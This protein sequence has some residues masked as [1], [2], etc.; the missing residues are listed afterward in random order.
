MK[1]ACRLGAIA[2]LLT[3]M[4]SAGI[5]QSAVV[6][7]DLVADGDSRFFE[8]ESGAFA[9][10]NQMHSSDPATEGYFSVAEDDNAAPNNLL[11]G[12][13]QRNIGN[14]S[15]FDIFSPVN[16]VEF[17]PTTG[18]DIFPNG[19]DFSDI[20]SLEYDALTGNVAALT[21]DFFPH[22]SDIDSFP[23]TTIGNYTTHTSNVI[24]SV[25]LSGGNVSGINLTADIEFNYG[26]QVSYDGIFRM[27]N[28]RFDLFVDE[29]PGV[30]SNVGNF[31]FRLSWD[32][33]G[34][35]E[36]LAAV[37][38]GDADGDLDVDG[39]DFLLWQRGVGSSGAGLGP[40][41]GNFNG[42]NTVDE[43]DLSV[44][45]ASYGPGSSLAATTIPEPTT[46]WLL[47]AFGASFSVVRHPK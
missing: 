24:G 25:T 4:L 6:G 30:P 22:V 31:P 14:E 18:L 13:L 40:A 35:I 32:I 29:R 16:F 20:G 27:T 1:K 21:L 44:W 39:S 38:T 23:A 15:A 36:G 11:N 47:L 12:V 45:T 9:Q 43:Q 41:N 8:L 17:N 2:C 26:G 3:L 33:E 7:L 37:L 28:N 10:I 19:A 5:A 46:L 34:T 42:D